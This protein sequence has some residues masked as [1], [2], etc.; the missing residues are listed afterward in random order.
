AKTGIETPMYPSREER[1]ADIE[2]GAGRPAQ[3][4]VADVQESNTRL[5]A[6]IADL[7]A[8]DWEAPIRFGKADREGTAA[9]IPGL[10][11]VE[12]E[13]HHVDL[14][15]DYTIAHWPEAF[16]ERMLSQTTADYSARPNE[17]SFVLVGNGDEG[18][19][20]VGDPG[21]PEIIGPPPALL[22]WLLGRT[23]GT[24]LQ[25]DGSLPKLEAWR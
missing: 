5:I 4:L 6:A 13:V 25:T 20:R 7:S 19:W 12:V 1:D 3:A 21:G 24:G 8:G 9:D 18:S 17:P 10:R 14:D 15:L 16:V 22:G 2:A 23:E 11:E